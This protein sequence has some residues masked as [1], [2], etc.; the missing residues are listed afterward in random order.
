MPRVLL[1]LPSATYRAPDFLDAAT[2]LG[3]EV[4]VGSEHRQ[5][6]SESMGDRAV[7]LTLSQPEL[8][9]DQ[10]ARLAERAPL[11]AIV[12]VDDGGTRA[13]AA[14]AARLG[15]RGNDPD[16]VAR[17]REKAAMREALDAAGVR[18]PA[19]ARHPEEVGYPC[20]LKPLTRAGSQGVIRADSADEAAAAADRIRRIV[21]DADAPL[22]VEEYVPGDEVAV[23]GLLTGGTLEVLAIFDKPDPLTGPFFEETIYV[24][25]SRKP[26]AT[27]QEIE[28]A[29]AEAA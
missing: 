23:E 29:T 25:P 1:V 5:A 19:W 15:L 20:V 2:R 6:L 24:T 4:V 18:Q 27:Q 21:G 7:T 9:A 26:E 22:L 16:A 10:I 8:A 17:A 3:A 13:A 28:S 11:D 14:A 12:A